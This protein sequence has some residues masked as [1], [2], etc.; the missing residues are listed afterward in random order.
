MKLHIT[1]HNHTSRVSQTQVVE[2]ITK[3]T[4]V[5]YIH[6]TVPIVVNTVLKCRTRM[7]ITVRIIVITV[8]C[9]FETSVN[10]SAIFSNIVI[11]IN[12]TVVIAHYIPV[13]TGTVPHGTPTP[14]AATT[15]AAAEHTGELR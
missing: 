3:K 13:L 2:I 12:R 10:H 9:S 6:H 11:T 14:V 1:K 4:P 8:I 15:T 5:Q 7:E